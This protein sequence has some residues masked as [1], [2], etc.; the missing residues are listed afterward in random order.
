MAQHRTPIESGCPDNKQY[1]HPA[2]L[3]NYGNWRYHDRP[4]PGVLHHV[5]NTG[6]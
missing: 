2:L 1:M 3:R 5:S 4:R 6:E